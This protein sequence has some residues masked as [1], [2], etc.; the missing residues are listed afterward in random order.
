MNEGVKIL[1]ERMKT[2]PD[3]FLDRGKWKN[4]IEGYASYLNPDDYKLI[5]EE[6]N[7]LHQQRFTEQVMKELLA[8]EE[9]DDMGKWFT[10]RG[11]ATV[12]AGVTPVIPSITLETSEHLRAHLDA[13]HKVEVRKKPVLKKQHKTLF[14]KLFNYS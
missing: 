6:L 9:D 2:N 10:T 12:S 4:L 13:L 1:L 11:N 3:E 5:R 7:K 8:P 14:G